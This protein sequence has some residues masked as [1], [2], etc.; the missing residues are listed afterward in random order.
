M[1]VLGLIR[2]VLLL[3]WLFI[4]YSV[5]TDARK[6][7]LPAWPWAIFVFL[8]GLIVLLIYYLVSRNYPIINEGEFSRAG[9]GTGFSGQLP[10][11]WGSPKGG[12]SAGDVTADPEFV[13]DYLEQLI[14]EG[15]LREAR[16]HM[17]DMLQVAR[18]MNDKKG[19]A[20]YKKYERK[21]ASSSQSGSRGG[22]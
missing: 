11:T 21:I 7:G 14:R 4:A 10:N 5:Y 15:R 9:A 20:N 8:T 13:D 17:N 22:I 3:L 1:E 12:Q 6:R 2:F 16:A 18:E 19:I